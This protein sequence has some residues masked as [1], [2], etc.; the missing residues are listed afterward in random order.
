MILGRQ[1]ILELV[2]NG[3]VEGFD[4]GCLG[5]AG[6]DLRLGRIYQITSD[7][8]I[9]VKDRKTPTV[10]EV[11]ADSFT[12]KPD[13]YVLIET[14]EKVNMPSNLAA[15]VLNR[16]SIFRCGATL[17]NALVDPGYRGTL[18]FG[19]KNLSENA[20]TLQAGARIAQI[21]FETVEGETVEYSGRYQ[22]G[23]VV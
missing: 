7:S 18:T 15:R 9:G 2:A 20:L 3:L 10:K 5:G 23:K 16:S 8:F 1:R 19:L 12:L 13:E 6:Y 17:V 11:S 4:L 22:G 14:V 21:V